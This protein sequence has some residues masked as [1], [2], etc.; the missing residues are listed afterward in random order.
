MHNIDRRV[1][2]R[3]L[4]AGYGDICVMG[5]MTGKDLYQ[6]LPTFWEEG[7]EYLAQ[8]SSAMKSDDHTVA[9]Q[10]GAGP[11]YDNRGAFD[12]FWGET[13]P[14]MYH[15]ELLR[16]E[17]RYSAPFDS[18][19][20]AV[21]RASDAGPKCEPGTG[22]Y[23]SPGHMRI[24]RVRDRKVVVDPIPGSLGIRYG[25]AFVDQGGTPGEALYAFAA[26]WCDQFDNSTGL[27]CLHG[28]NGTRVLGFRSSDSALK[29]WSSN[30]ALELPAEYQRRG[31]RVFNTD[32]H[33]GP[34]GSGYIMVLEMQGHSWCPGSGRNFFATHPG[35]DL[36]QGWTLLDPTAGYVHPQIG[37]TY[38]SACPSVRFIKPFFYLVFSDSWQI[39]AHNE[40]RADWGAHYHEM[41]YQYVSRSKDLKQWELA[42]APIVV[43]DAVED[44]RLKDGYTPS[45]S[46]AHALSDMNDTNVSDL[47]MVCSC[48]RSRYR[49]PV[50]SLLVLA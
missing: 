48:S 7:V 1:V 38:G 6:V 12:K 45:A 14:L 30:V 23:C 4:H 39:A 43:P 40:S 2:D 22:Y 36:S 3:F 10:A 50:P 35:G 26:N 24:R 32:V 44:K 37:D 49:G 20:T 46:N 27:R 29:E 34:A 9:R 15:G 17:T 16:M 21:N 11:R 25:S 41:L 8:K 33:P 18:A 31:C 42:L 28:T 13:S 47:D 19:A 5:V